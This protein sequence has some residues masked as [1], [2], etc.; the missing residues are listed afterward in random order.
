MMPVNTLQISSAKLSVNRAGYEPRI[1]TVTVNN[2]IPF[3][4]TQEALSSTLGNGGLENHNTILN[5]EVTSGGD[6]GSSSIEMAHKH[7]GRGTGSIVNHDIDNI[8]L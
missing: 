5:I 2:P 4:S 1:P 3:N 7:R 6:A 8:D